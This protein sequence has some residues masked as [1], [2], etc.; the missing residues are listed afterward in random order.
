MQQGIDHQQAEAVLFLSKVKSIL[1]FRRGRKAVR[2]I[3]S[4]ADTGSARWTE[5]YWGRKFMESL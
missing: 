1:T 3:I 4:P 5:T 2:K